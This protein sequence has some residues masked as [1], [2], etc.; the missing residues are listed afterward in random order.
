[1]SA[2]KLKT[3]LRRLIFGVSVADI[4]S[5]ISFIFEPIMNPNP[6]WAYGNQGT[7]YASEFILTFG[8]VASALYTLALCIYYLHVIRYNTLDRDFAKRIE[9]W[10]H[11]I[12]IAIPLLGTIVRLTGR[13]GPNAVIYMDIF[14]FVPVFV[15][16]AGIV[17][18]MVVISWAVIKQERRNATFRFQIQAT[19]DGNQ[20]TC[21]G[22]SFCRHLRSTIGKLVSC[23]TR[24]TSAIEEIPTY[25]TRSLGA[26]QRRVRETVYQSLLYIG[27]FIIAWLAEVVIYILFLMNTPPSFPLMVADFSLLPL[28]GFF[29]ILVYTRPK[30]TTV[31]RRRPEYW[32]FQAFWMV[33]KA[34][35]EMPELPRRHQQTTTLASGNHTDIS[36]MR[37]TLAS[38]AQP[39]SSGLREEDAIVE[40]LGSSNLTEQPDREF[41]FHAEKE[42]GVVEQLELGLVQIE[43][44]EFN[45]DEAE[46]LKHKEQQ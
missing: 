12:S 13:Q 26:S 4:L 18:I 17:Y 35:G 31:R 40:V 37:R 41:R 27:A 20:N 24:E 21:Y 42:D 14:G 11:C 34:G 5:S 44:E 36:A 43:E 28:C 45:V 39:V 7:A 16:F 29:N 10:L 15:S 32:W 8:V 9:P 22:Y 30:V 25:A 46:T 3:P 23:G 38:P 6:V 33:M 2:D 19:R 1:M